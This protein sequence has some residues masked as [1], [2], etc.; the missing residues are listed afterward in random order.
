MI[1]DESERLV[2]SGKSTLPIAHPLKD[3]FTGF[4][5]MPEHAIGFRESLLRRWIAERHFAIEAT[6]Y[7]Y[8]CGRAQSESV[9][10]QDMLVLRKPR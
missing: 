3:Y 10:Y 8:W 5:D 6:Y 9:S 1:N 7:G 2:K 4:P